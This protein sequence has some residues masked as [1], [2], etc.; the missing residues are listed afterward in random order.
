MYDRGGIANQQE[1]EDFSINGARTSSMHKER[2]KMDS[3][4]TNMNCKW[5]KHFGVK[6]KMQSFQMM[7]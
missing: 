3:Q 5:I 2:I 4:Y 1:K 7:I 6:G